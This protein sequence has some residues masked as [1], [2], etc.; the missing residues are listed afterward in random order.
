VE[1]GAGGVVGAL[2]VG[3]RRHVLVAEESGVGSNVVVALGKGSGWVG[4]EAWS[5]EYEYERVGVESAWEGLRGDVAV[6]LV[7]EEGRCRLGE[8]GGPG[9]ELG[10][11]V[12]KAWM[13]RAGEGVA[14]W[15]CGGHTDHLPSCQRRN[16]PRNDAVSQ[17]VQ[18]NARQ[19]V[20]G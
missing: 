10:G 13:E 17:V 9:E 5:G 20:T 12:V 4:G 11:G 16:R 8:R 1:E 19:A 18:P 15:A 7:E 14:E 2:R 3:R 6:V